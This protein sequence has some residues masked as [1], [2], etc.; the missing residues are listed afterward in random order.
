M[1][2]KVRYVDERLAEPDARVQAARHWR[3]TLGAYR[4]A[5]DL[6][7]GAGLVQT[8]S[9]LPEF[10]AESAAADEARAGDCVAALRHLVRLACG[11]ERNAARLGADDQFLR[12]VAG[13]HDVVHA[14]NGGGGGASPSTLACVERSRANIVAYAR[15]LTADQ[16]RLEPELTRAALER[17]EAE[18]YRH[19]DYLTVRRVRMTRHSEELETLRVPPLFRGCQPAIGLAKV[20]YSQGPL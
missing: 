1:R 19:L 16:I 2:A 6:C 17:V 12:F 9:G 10:A 20:H 11:V 3:Q 8:R 5:C 13:L 15:A 14:W 4:A 7:V 18:L